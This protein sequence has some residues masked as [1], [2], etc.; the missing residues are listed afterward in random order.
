MCLPRHP[1]PLAA[2]LLLA[3]LLSAPTAPA[4][5]GGLDLQVSDG[6]GKPLT[7]AVVFVE[8]PAAKAALRPGAAVEI[9]Q[10]NRQFSPAVTVVAVGTAV[11]FPNRDTVRH[12]LYSFSP[13]KKFEI[14]LYVGTP[15]A[16]VVFDAPGVAVLG[17][18]IHDNMAAWVLVVES[19]HFGLTGS[20]GKLSLAQVPAGHYRLRAW[21]ASLPPGTAAHDQAVQVPTSG[22]AQVAVRL[23]GASQ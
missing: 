10:I 9:A 2:A 11:S 14:K 18:N 22:S 23:A 3:A 4:R 15:A 7:G 12:H 19:N 8:S 16:P 20:D 21:H 5:A 1:A 6:S 17:C 13:T